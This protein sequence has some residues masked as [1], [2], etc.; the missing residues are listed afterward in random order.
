LD[1]LAGL[2][3]K[4][5]VDLGFGW[6]LSPL[7]EMMDREEDRLQT[8]LAE[9]HRKSFAVQFEIRN[10]ARGRLYDRQVKLFDAAEVEWQEFHNIVGKL[11]A[12]LK[13][14]RPELSRFSA[15]QNSG[16]MPNGPL[17]LVMARRR[18]NPG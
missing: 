7:V 9:T 5:L 1:G 3:T 2:C 4:E 15:S 16:Q 6:S 18:R 12:T 14:T 13:A 17:G 11:R 8:A 10:P